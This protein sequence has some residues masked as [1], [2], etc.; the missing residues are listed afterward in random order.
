[1]TLIACSVGLQ[2]F[3]GERKKVHG[4]K[5]ENESERDFVSAHCAKTKNDRT[6]AGV[7]SIYFLLNWFQYF[8][9]VVVI[10]QNLDWNRRPDKGRT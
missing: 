2:D 5:G 9:I 1:M 8:Q 3:A 6:R 7:V 10:N 4:R